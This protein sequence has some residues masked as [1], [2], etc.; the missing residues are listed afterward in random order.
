MIECS[1][2]FFCFLANHANIIDSLKSLSLI[3]AGIIGLF[4]IARRANAQK[5]SALSAER[6]AATAEKGHINDRY[7]KAIDQLGAMRGNEPNLEVRLGGIYGLEQVSI[8][9]KDLYPQIIEV[10]TAYIRTNAVI[11]SITD[12]DPKSAY[13]IEVKVRPKVDVQA[14][15]TVLGR[16]KTVQGEKSLNFSRAHLAGYSFAEGDFSSATFCR[17]D[18]T[19]ANFLAADCSNSRFDKANLTKASFEWATC[20]GMILSGAIIEG[21]DFLKA[22]DLPPGYKNKQSSKKGDA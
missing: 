17:A 11:P 3:G 4:Y 8:E 5:I 16:R 20:T 10:L 7:T 12:E 15:I 9:S 18:C 6:Q 14:A 1:T 19:N 22:T 21:V 13:Q 2:G